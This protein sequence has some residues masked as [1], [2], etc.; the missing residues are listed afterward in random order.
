MSDRVG[1]MGL[2]SRILSYLFWASSIFYNT[3]QKHFRD[4]CSSRN[5]RD[6]PGW[7]THKHNHAHTSRQD[8][9]SEVKCWVL[10][11]WWTQPVPFSSI[12]SSDHLAPLL[13]WG[14]WPQLCLCGPTAPAT[15]WHAWQEDHERQNISLH[16]ASVWGTFR[17]IVAV[18]WSRGE[19]AP[20][21]LLFNQ[22]S[23][24]WVKINDLWVLALTGAYSS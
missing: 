19:P 21:L 22:S 7:N 10:R 18:L 6:E 11:I 23:A 13:L 1:S 3:G 2:N 8:L 16:L 14:P 5:M 4:P 20:S 15:P 12:S 9:G 24:G 17:E